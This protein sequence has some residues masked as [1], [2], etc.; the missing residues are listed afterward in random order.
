MLVLDRP[1]VLDAPAPARSWEPAE[2]APG[3]AGFFSRLAL[4]IGAGVSAAR[5][6]AGD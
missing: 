6:L 4:G 3:P 2:D 5:P 1:V